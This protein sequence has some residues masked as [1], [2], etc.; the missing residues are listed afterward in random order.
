MR[1]EKRF[2]LTET[3]LTSSMVWKRCCK[4]FSA[5]SVNSKALFVLL[6][7]VII[8]IKSALASAFETIGGA[9]TSCGKLRKA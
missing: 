4:T 7:K 5:Y 3:L 6:L 9:S 8:T 2:P 1:M